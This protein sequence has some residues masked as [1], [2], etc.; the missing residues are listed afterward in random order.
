MERLELL[1]GI[2]GVGQAAPGNAPGFGP[3]RRN[4]RGR[5]RGRGGR[6]LGRG[7]R[8]LGQGNHARPHN[9]DR[10]GEER[11]HIRE[12]EEN[13]ADPAN[14]DQGPRPEGEIRV[15]RAVRRRRGRALG[16]VS[17][18]PMVDHDRPLH[19][20]CPGR[21]LEASEDWMDECR[22]VT[23]ERVN[24]RSNRVEGGIEALGLRIHR[25]E[26]WIE[27]VESDR[28]RWAAAYYPPLPQG[29]EAAAPPPPEERE[30][31]APAQAQAPPPPPAPAVPAPVPTG[32]LDEDEMLM[33]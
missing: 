15:C 2:L 19:L 5:R 18:P 11:P 27:L 3:N 13:P 4:R 7:G 17:P 33:E 26:R 9:R 31:P 23:M 30:E 22:R 10:E 16:E 24:D 12:P 6:F 28:Q 29:N 8:F 20:N 32:E 25:I 14:P 1:A 21:S